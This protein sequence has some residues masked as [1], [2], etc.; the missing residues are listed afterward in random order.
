MDRSTIARRDQIQ[1][2]LSRQIGGQ[3]IWDTRKTGSDAILVVRWDFSGGTN[4]GTDQSEGE[5]CKADESRSGK[6]VW[7]DGVASIMAVRPAGF[8]DGAVYTAKR[9]GTKTISGT[10]RPL[11]VVTGVHVQAGSSYIHSIGIAAGLVEVVKRDCA[12]VLDTSEAVIQTTIAGVAGD[13]IL[14]L[15]NA[16]FTV[17]TFAS[18][19]PAPIGSR[20]DWLF[21]GWVVGYQ[22][23]PDY[24]AGAGRGGGGSNLRIDYGESFDLVL[25]RVDPSYQNFGPTWFGKLAYARI[26]LRMRITGSPGALAIIATENVS[27]SLH[28]DSVIANYYLSKSSGGA[29]APTMVTGEVHVTVQDRDGVDQACVIAF[30]F[31]AYNRLTAV[32]ATS[33]ILT[34]QAIGGRR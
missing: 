1:D 6:A 3:R 31:D 32:A 25:G 2:E 8:G 5:L 34:A 24:Q 12:R 15:N 4:G 29:S 28:F 19:T 7:V 23:L 27:W 13:N 10:T 14:A 20:Y 18:A 30:Y 17:Q 9:I 21:G 22:V 33:G 26:Q 16:Y 11:Y